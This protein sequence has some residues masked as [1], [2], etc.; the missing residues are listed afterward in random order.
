VK[1]KFEVKNGKASWSNKFENESVPYK[2][3]LY[4]N[5]YG[6]PGK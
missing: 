2:G 4:S 5:M 6:N 1:E 3:E